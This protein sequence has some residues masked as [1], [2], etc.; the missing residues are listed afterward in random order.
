MKR[1]LNRLLLA[2]PLTA[3]GC[4]FAANLR[5]NLVVSPLYA[6]T[7]R[8]DHHRHM[9]MGREAWAEMANAYPDYEYSCD[10]RRGFVEGFADYLDYGGIGEPPPIPPPIYRI[11][12]YETPAG[13]A[14]M[15]DWTCGFRHGAAT[16]MKSGLR[17][18]ATI[19]I[20][21]GP[22]YAYPPPESIRPPRNQQSAPPVP[23]A[24]QQIPMPPTEV[25]V[26]E[27]K[28]N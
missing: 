24:P 19:P 23:G 14:M 3:I 13:L 10:Y 6:A 11:A 27:A 28:A 7:E 1:W 4:S 2:A 22:T 20:Y 21:K 8:V 18:L 9:Q 16:A 25:P 12:R 17:E 26:T 5:E 15:E